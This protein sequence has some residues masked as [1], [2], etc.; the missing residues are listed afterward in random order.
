MRYINILIAVAHDFSMQIR[1]FERRWT[2]PCEYILTNL[3]KEFPKADNSL[4]SSV[5]VGEIPQP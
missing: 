4:T 2:Q 3:K 1:V 5:L